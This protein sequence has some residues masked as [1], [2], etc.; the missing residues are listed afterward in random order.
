M[1][2]LGVLVAL[3]PVE[4]PEPDELEPAVF[5]D[6]DPV[7]PVE[8]VELVVAPELDAAVFADVDAFAV[9]V[10]V[11]RDS[12]G[13]FPVIRT[14]AISAQSTRNSPTEYPITRLRIVRTRRCR[15]CLILTASVFPMRKRIGSPRSKRV[16]G[17]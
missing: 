17:P 9:A 8:P 7:E 16:R 4:L 2:A 15:I 5:E 13:S 6:A 1:T 12:A 14:T 10:L 11:L 3:E